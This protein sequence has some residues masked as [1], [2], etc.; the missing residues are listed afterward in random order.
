MRDLNSAV[1][2]PSRHMVPRDVI[3]IHAM[4]RTHVVQLLK[5]VKGH[6]HVGV[7]GWTLPNVF[8][9]PGVTVH[10]V[11]DDALKMLTLDFVKLTLL[12][13]FV[14]DN[15][16]NNDTLVE[17]LSRLLPSFGGK[18]FRVRCFAHIINLVAK[19]VLSPFAGRPTKTQLLE[20]ATP[21]LDSQ[22]AELEDD[23]GEGYVGDE[24]VI[25]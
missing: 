20:P 4:T 14:S 9:F 10:Y 6:L 19:A 12:L 24:D 23:V 15:G 13:G 8:A 5:N 21:Q 22:L 7:D 1:E 18:S 17:E 11:V 25:R 2:N 3:E 16:S